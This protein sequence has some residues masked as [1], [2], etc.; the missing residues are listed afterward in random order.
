MHNIYSLEVFNGQQFVEESNIATKIYII[1]TNSSNIMD[2]QVKFGIFRRYFHFY[3]ST[4]FNKTALLPNNSLQLYDIIP[5]DA[6]YVLHIQEELTNIICVLCLLYMLYT[7]SY[8]C[9]CRQKMCTTRK[10][11]LNR[12]LNIATYFKS[13]QKRNGGVV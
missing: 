9:A 5:N 10:F 11:S 6:W 13:T 7:Y 1:Y 3:L 2:S 12:C 8:Y 4:Q